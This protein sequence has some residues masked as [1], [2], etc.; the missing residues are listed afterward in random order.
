MH[1]KLLPTQVRENVQLQYAALYTSI[2]TM[3]AGL[4]WHMPAIHTYMHTYIYLRNVLSHKA[5]QLIYTNSVGSRHFIHSAAKH[6]SLVCDR[7]HTK[8]LSIPHATFGFTRNL[9]S[10][11]SPTQHKQKCSIYTNIHYQFI[12][13]PPNETSIYLCVCACVKPHARESI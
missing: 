6:L 13:A 1:A 10:K 2:A 3:K 8:S 5:H 11:A 12:E 4:W 7:Q 9:I